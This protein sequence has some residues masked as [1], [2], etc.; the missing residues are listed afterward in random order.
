MTGDE[1]QEWAET[2]ADVRQLPATVYLVG[3]SGPQNVAVRVV[4]PGGFE[5]NGA[6]VVDVAD[7]E[8][9]AS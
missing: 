3:A 9:S 2:L 7:P 4:L 8:G 1:Q 6:A 5:V